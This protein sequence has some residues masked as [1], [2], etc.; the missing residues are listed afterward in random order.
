MP[1]TRSPVST[2]ELHSAANGMAWVSSSHG[3]QI[4]GAV[5]GG[6]EPGGMYVGRVRHNSGDLLPG[7]VHLN[8]G[9]IYVPYGGKEHNFS[10]Y[11]V[12]TELNPSN[13]VT[14]W[15]HSQHGIVPS[16]AIQGGVTSRGERLYIGRARIN[17]VL[18][19]GKIHPSHHALYVSYGGK[20]H[21][22]KE[23]YEILIYR[24]PP[25]RPQISGGVAHATSASSHPPTPRRGRLPL[26]SSV[27]RASVPRAPARTGCAWPRNRKS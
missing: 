27:A 6:S 22:F 21:A 11:E 16:T 12:L 14:E 2:N 25:R 17:G 24:T 18:S 4:E 10:S 19:C 13:P 20:E 23:G 9:F 8:Y 15:R 5:M 7:K 1:S 3:R 26:T